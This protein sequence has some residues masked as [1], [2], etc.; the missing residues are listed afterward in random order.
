M[1]EKPAYVKDF[2]KPSKTEIKHIGKGWYLYECSSKYDP[3]VKRS[4][5]ISGKCLGLITP[6]GLIKTTRRL[7]KVSPWS[8]AS[9]T[10]DDVLHVGGPVFFFERTSSLRERLCRH[11]PDLW[12]LIYVSALL[13][14]EYEPVFKR[15]PM[16]Y[17]S[18]FLACMFPD[19]SFGPAERS[20]LLQELG[21]HRQAMCEFMKE[22]LSDKNVFILFDGHRL[23]S[24]SQSMEYAELGYDSKRRFMPQINLMYVFSLDSENGSP[25]YYKQFVG[26]TPDVS[27]FSD[28]LK[29][30]GIAHN[31]C[32][33]VADKGFASENDFALL[34][35]R[36]L[37]YIIPI[38]RGN[39]YTKALLPINHTSFEEVFTYNGRA[40]QAHKIEENGFNVFV[41]YDAIL[42]A[43]ELSDC[44][45][46]AEKDNNSRQKQI[47]LEN[48]RRNRGKGRLS[49]D[50]LKALKPKNLVEFR[51]NNPEMGTVSI[52]TNQTK[53]NSSQVYRIYK[54]RQAIEQFFKTYGDT[55][56][57]EASYMRSQKTQEAWLFLNHICAM[58][59]MDCINSIAAADCD[60]QI[61]FNDLREA[62]RKITAFKMD[63]KWQVA[64]IKSKV[65]RVL[66]KL[67]VTINNEELASALET[68][69][70]L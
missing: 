5:K 40:I 16:H 46:R 27:A 50:E 6:N 65:I 43:N 14:L 66:K 20:A 38:R 24:S 52:R 29:E 26:S 58:L 8:S 35:E 42:Y 33:I 37:Q 3:K 25:V 15:L 70:K 28:I 68:C 7:C 17:E 45:D 57:F 55:L 47:E 59:G 18:S 10:V 36:E 19:L 13:R 41:Y 1:I 9:F 62:L 51:N 49:D 54:Q 23:I 60:K 12:K 63:E 22:D 34:D 32:T 61:S 56:G 39:E 53:L 11:F 44:I 30:S 48:T 21:K 2:P 67:N 4:R 64:P 69:S 31:T